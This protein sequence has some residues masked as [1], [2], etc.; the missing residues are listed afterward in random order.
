MLYAL[1][2][3]A[4]RKARAGLHEI[5]MAGV[6]REAERACERLPEAFQGEYLQPEECLAEDR[7]ELLAFYDCP[8]EHWRHLRTTNLVETLFATV[9]L[10]AAKTRGCASCRTAFVTVYRLMRATEGKWRKLNGTEHLPRVIEIAVVQSKDGT[11]AL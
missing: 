1:P 10:R 8:A 11:Q 5:W 9:R 3:D 7:T 2:K 4:Q 6:K